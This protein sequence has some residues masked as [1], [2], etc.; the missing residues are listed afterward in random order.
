[1]YRVLVSDKISQEGVDILKEESHI[2]VE[3]SFGMSKD[4]LKRIIGDFD[5]IIIRSATKL[6]RD[7]LEEAKN[8]KV[9]GRAGSGLDNVDVEFATRRGIVVMNT[10]GGNTITTAEHAISLLLSCVRKIPQATA[11]MKE[12][13]WEK[14]KFIGVE[15]TD[16]V[17]GVVGL[18][19]VGSAVAERAKGLKMR[20]LGYDP[21]ISQERAEHLGVKLV[22][23]DEL[24]KESDFITIHT[25]L[26][27]STR[28]LID[29]S[30]FSKMKRGV[31]IVNCARGG[32][33]NE[34][35]LYDAIKEGIVQGAALDVF[36]K[37]PPE[38]LPLFDLDEVV[39]TPHL[40]ASTHEAQKKV[41]IDVAKQIIDFLVHGIVRNAV[42]APSVKEELLPRVRRYMELAEKM[43]SFHAQMNAEGLFEV[44]VEYCGEV[45]NFDTRP[46]TNSLLKGILSPILT[47]P[48]NVI[49]A[50]LV[51][52]DRGIRIV[53]TKSASTTEYMTLIIMR[54][55]GKHGGS[56]LAGTI[57]DKDN[58]RIVRIDNFRVEVP[59]EGNMLVLYA[60]DRP[61]VIGN[62]GTTLGNAEINIARMH[63][64]REKEAGKALVLLT[65]DTPVPKDVVERLEALPHMLSVKQV[66]L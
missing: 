8:L 10:P 59:P 62:I 13:K 17:L 25:P 28:N 40:G 11:S 35:D 63:F 56:L 31:F 5:G 64:G 9:I 50:P 57:F 18:G 24:L 38:R 30:A 23:L 37:E 26:N 60:N 29:K 66:N 39:L 1:M 55:K 20:V 44:N 54:I 33:V 43:G 65:T 34:M 51:A 2:E 42:N 16:K 21:Y 41:A 52:K 36:E 32:I 7:V 27:E 4:E 12:G 47:E 3:V 19:R 61:G 22:N 53:E 48:V 46:I 45:S 6:T 14:S 49:N 58:P 15:V